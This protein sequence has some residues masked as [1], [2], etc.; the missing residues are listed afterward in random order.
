MKRKNILFGAALT[1]AAVFIVSLASCSLTG[2]KRETEKKEDTSSVTTAREG[3]EDVTVPP[4][5]TTD[6][7]ADSK[8]EETTATD[9]GITD[10][11]KAVAAARE[12]LGEKDEETGYKY[13]YSFDTMM[14]EDGVEYYKIRVSWYITEEERY[15]L[16]G[17]LL[18]DA[19]G[20]VTKYDW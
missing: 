2:D 17:Y 16:C 10:S 7:A 12:Y 1:L 14:T 3:F 9:E 13:A 6:K 15:A 5:E 19:D 4:E 20:N 11:D 8:T 18:V